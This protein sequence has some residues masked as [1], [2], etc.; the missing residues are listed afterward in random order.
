M[1][2]TSEEMLRLLG[3]EH[4]LDLA[5]S[6]NLAHGALG[7]RLDR[8]LRVLEVEDEILGAGRVDA[9]LHVEIDVDDVLVAGEHQAFLEDVAAAALRAWPVADRDGAPGAHVRLQHLADRIGQVVA[10]A[11]AGRAG[12]AAEDHV[13]ADLVRPD[14]V[15]AGREPQHDRGEEDDRGGLAAEGGAARDDGLEPVLAAAQ[16][17]LEI[18]R[19]AAA[20]A[21]GAGAPRTAAARAAALPPRAAA[22]ALVAP[23]HVRACPSP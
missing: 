2:L 16:D 8:A 19:A 15:E 7:D 5:A 9:P 12:V 17:L 23:R 20:R 3:R 14:G 22:A 21:L 1:S 10:Q 6:H 18:G 4:G 11:F 13:D